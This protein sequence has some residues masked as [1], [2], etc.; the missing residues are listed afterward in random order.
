MAYSNFA[1]L[2]MLAHDT[3]AAISWGMRA[4]ELAEQ[5]GESEILVH[6]LNNVG[7]AEVYAG[8]GA[9]KLEQSLA[10]ALEAGLEEHVAR[11]YTNLG[12]TAVQT[13]SPGA[14]AYLD[15]GIEYSTEHDLDSWRLYM[16]GWR[17]R[18]EL[19][20]A[21]WDDAAAT[22]MLVLDQPRTAVPPRIMPLV[23]LGL[24]RARRGDPDAWGPLDE[25]SALAGP[26]EEP[27]RLAP[28]AA[29]RAEAAWLVGD[30][31]R[32]AAE[33]VATARVRLENPWLAG[34]RAVW[35]RRTGSPLMDTA[36]VPEP[37]AHELDGD[38]DGASAAWTSVGCLYDA[39]FVLVFA[40][41]IDSL[42]R[43]HHQLLELGATAAAAVAARR[44]RER[45]VRGLPRGPRPRTLRNPRQLTAREVEILAFVADGLRNAAIA[46]RLFVSRRTVD[47]HVSAILRKL[48]VASR[49]QA[50]AE[51]RRLGLLERG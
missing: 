20:R 23:V 9:A 33:I 25:A 6:A 34:E 32:A 46:D 29:A 35:A 27:Q 51:A 44:L 13:R 36:A 16:L 7:T 39:A 37:Y 21:L 48:D 12:S 42:R 2:R 22:A 24:V 30:V 3:Q 40:E 49:G 38:I 31:Q 5:L 19:D 8:Q 45:G 41:D 10:L 4:I 11:A 15:A 1:Q 14:A 26:T 43:A 18:D 28:V 17:A 47:H 50:V